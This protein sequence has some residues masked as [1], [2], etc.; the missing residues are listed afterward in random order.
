MGSISALLL[1]QIDIYMSDTIHVLIIYGEFCYSELD[2]FGYLVLP[3][4]ARFL[5]SVL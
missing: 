4:S 5:C 3:G 1:L 2:C